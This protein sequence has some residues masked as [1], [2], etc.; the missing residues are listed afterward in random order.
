MGKWF[1]REGIGMMVYSYMAKTS[2]WEPWAGKLTGM[3]L[4]SED[5]VLQAIMESRDVLD[6][7]VMRARQLLKE[8]GTSC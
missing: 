3:I 5:K 2:E 1:S 4:E 8:K 7:N 6:H